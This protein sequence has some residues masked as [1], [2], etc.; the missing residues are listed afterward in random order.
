MSNIFIGAEGNIVTFINPIS[1]KKQKG[2][3]IK[4]TDKMVTIKSGST[5]STVTPD[6]VAEDP[7]ELTENNMKNK[8]HIL[9]N[10]IKEQVKKQLNEYSFGSAH[11]ELVHKFE[12]VLGEAYT[13]EDSLND[14]V[15][16]SELNK[17]KFALKKIDDG[18]RDL[19]NAL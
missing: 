11:D 1:G 8:Q 6:M 12:T 19:I 13:F 10:L 5:E 4:V 16:K 2:R 18:I 17:V 14:K 9:R 15:T 3:I 7:T